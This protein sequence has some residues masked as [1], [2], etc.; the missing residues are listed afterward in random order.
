M[1]RL[2]LFCYLFQTKCSRNSMSI[3]YRESGY[4]TGYLIIICLDLRAVNLLLED[5]IK[6]I[7]SIF[8]RT[9][10]LNLS[11]EHVRESHD[12]CLALYFLMLISGQVVRFC[13]VMMVRR[14]HRANEE[15]RLVGITKHKQMNP[16][17]FS[18]SLNINTFAYM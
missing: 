8:T 3:Q 4:L 9:R 17:D 12:A 11:T 7:K 6:L 14:W 10:Q 1:N 13:F 18:V 15:P 5:I 16:K 2:G